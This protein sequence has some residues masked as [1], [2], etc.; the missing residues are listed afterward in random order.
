M[1]FVLHVPDEYDYRYGCSNKTKPED[2][3]NHRNN[4]IKTILEN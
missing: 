3:F 2:A 1:E 4:I